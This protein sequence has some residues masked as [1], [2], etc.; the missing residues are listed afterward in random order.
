MGYL[1]DLFGFI[2]RLLYQFF[3]N[4]GVAII[5]LT[6]IIRSALIPLNLRSQKA[7]IKMQAMSS[8]TAELQRKYGDDKEKYQEELMKLQ[9]E[10]GAGGRAGCLLPFLQLFFL[11]PLFR[12]V[13]APLT[14]LSKVSVENINS[15]IAVGRQMHFVDERASETYQIGLIKAL[16]ESGSFLGECV[17]RG[18]I[19]LEQMIDFHFLGIDLTMTPAWNPKTIIGDPGTYVPLLIMVILVLVTI[20]LPMQLSKILKPGYKEEKERKERSN[21]PARAGQGETAQAANTEAT[22]KMMTWVMPIIMLFTTFT[23]PAAMGLY[24]IVGGIMGIIQQFL[25]Y[26]LFT[27]PY[28]LKKK[29]LEEQKKNVFKKKKNTDNSTEETGNKSGKKSNKK[30]K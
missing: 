30:R 4:Y 14:Y 15:M 27:K 10:N 18:F 22:M 11:Y 26:Y 3:G 5:F 9:K 20:V 17:K 24:W 2:T 21:N 19:S 7:M 16:N 6:I 1:Y 29:E 25:T 28:E 8:K 12:M 13:Q 23:M